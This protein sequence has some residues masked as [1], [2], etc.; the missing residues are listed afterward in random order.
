MSTLSRRTFVKSVAAGSTFLIA[1]S[2]TLRTYAQNNIV[3]VACIGTGARGNYHLRNG[4]AS[5]E[6]LRIV[7]VADVFQPNQ[8]QGALYAQLANAK[9][10][11]DEGQGIE[12]LDTDTQAKV[13][14][15]PRP[16]AYYDYKQ[17]LA[18]LGDKIDAVVI[19]SPPYTHH[20]ILMHC[21]D[22]NKWVFCEKS[23]VESIEH[24]REIVQKC[25]ETGTFVQVG[26]QR[27]YDPRYNRAMDLVY[28]D[29]W[30]GRITHLSAQ[31]HRSGLWARSWQDEYGAD[32]VLNE[33]EKKFIPDLEHHLNWNLYSATSG[34]LLSELGAHQIDVANWFMRGV[35]ARVH[36]FGAVDYWRDGREVEDHVQ[37]VFEYDIRPG[38]PGFHEVV[39]RSPR[40]DR[41]RINAAYGVRFS[42]SSILSN[43]KQGVSEL[44]QGDRGSL[45]LS[46]RGCKLFHEPVSY[47][48]LRNGELPGVRGKVGEIKPMSGSGDPAVIPWLVV[49]GRALLQDCELKHSDVYQFEDFVHHIQDGGKPRANEMVGLT[50]AIS[51]IAARQSLREKR[52]IEIDPA[53]YHFD[54]D[55]PAYTDYEFDYAKYKCEPKPLDPSE[56]GAVIIPNES[57]D[58]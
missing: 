49:K 3:Q 57:Q 10:V 48:D 34:G 55:T 25:H 5:V 21:L 15:T 42:Y 23:M 31:W 19:A 33:E 39:P 11:L 43:Q 32:Y 53:S 35:P 13:K 29:N 30:V 20:E 26:Y 46:E 36:S 28:G 44:I 16:P 45:E 17:M 51:V 24:G 18:E 40:Q 9:V 7:G 52:S 50:T 27:R 8:R 58:S 14:A 4:L 2:A 6:D 56:G 54:F 37:A 38:M 12:N 47:R 1:Q 22:L 41:D